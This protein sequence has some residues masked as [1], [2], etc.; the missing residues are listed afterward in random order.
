MTRIAIIGGGLSGLTAANFLKDHA[1]VTLFEKARGVSGRMST[2]RAEPYFFD[3]G[4]Q[5]FTAQTDA[6]QSFIAPMIEKGVIQR[7][8]AQFVSIRHKKIADQRQWNEDKPHYVG[9]PGMN[10][11]AKYLA[12]GLNIHVGT[13]V[14]SISRNNGVW[15][16]EDEQ[17]NALGAYDWVISTIP[18]EQATVLL[19]SSLSF[20]PKISAVTMQGCFT[21][22]LG[23]TEALPL[24]F[25]AAWVEGEDISWISVNSSKP[26]RNETYCLLAHSTNQWADEHIDDDRDQVMAYLCQQVS[27]IIGYDV[28][29]AAHKALHGW[30]YANVEKQR[31]ETF[32]LE[33]DQHIAVC[34]DWLIEGKV[35]AAFTSAMQLSKKLQD[36][37]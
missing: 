27:S 2:R 25:D 22:M 30:R 15:S 16:L 29:Q 10:A 21:L 19:P 14:A 17:G 28:S 35:E 4:A 31:G 9:V 24:E 33:A 3:H 6:F 32:F 37:L 12:Q 18:A 1:D 7:W 26:G 8:D 34:G 11:I 36:I 13:R 5:F 23:F 20:Y